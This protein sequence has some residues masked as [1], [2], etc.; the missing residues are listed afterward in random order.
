MIDM[1]HINPTAAD[2]AV[3]VK[4]AAKAAGIS[5][6]ELAERAGIPHTT[7]NRKLNNG[8]P[9]HWD[10]LRAI[11]SVIGRSVSSLAAETEVRVTAEHGAAA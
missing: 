4:S 5:Q 11:S 10:E 8:A 7:L 6:R 1:E 2:L 3:T 9:L